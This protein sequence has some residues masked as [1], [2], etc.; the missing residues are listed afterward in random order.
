MSV[1]LIVGFFGIILFAIGS[2]L[3]GASSDSVAYPY[4]SYQS[5]TVAASDGTD[6]Y[7]YVDDD[8]PEEIP[9]ITLYKDDTDIGRGN[10]ILINPEHEFIIPDDIDLFTVANYEVEATTVY[11]DGFQLLRHIIAPLDRMKSSYASETDP[12][13]VA[14]ISAFRSFEAQQEMQERRGHYAADPGYSEHH[15][16]LAIDLG[17]WAEGYLGRFTGTDTATWFAQNSYRYG[18][19]LRYPEDRTHI[20]N[21]PYEPWHFRY[22][23]LPHSYV[24]FQ[25]D[26]VLEEYIDLLRSHTIYNPLIVEHDGQTYEIYFTTERVI[27]FPM[28]TVFDISGNNVDGFIITIMHQ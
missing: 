28:D 20:T 17:I 7:D 9:T 14:I 11:Y 25:R 3:F 4:S 26:L 19:I 27:T 16:G 2:A 13:N 12:G 8:Y 21:T 15:S 6:D 18:F 23:G 5:A 10:L 24:M 22:V 1:I